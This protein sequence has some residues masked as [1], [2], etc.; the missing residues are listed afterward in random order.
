VGVR[1]KT[2]EKKRTP[3]FRKISKQGQE[4][5]P[6]ASTVS[7]ARDL[8][9]VGPGGTARPG[10]IG[11]Q[12]EIERGASDP[13][14]PGRRN[15]PAPDE[16]GRWM[17]S[18]LKKE[19]VEGMREEDDHLEK[20]VPGEICTTAGLVVADLRDDGRG[21]PHKYR[22]PVRGIAHDRRGRVI[23]TEAGAAP[24]KNRKVIP[25]N[26][27][28]HTLVGAGGRR[29]ARSTASN[30]LKPGALSAGRRYR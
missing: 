9:R 2:K 25:L 26:R 10:L 18:R 22:R 23:E 5:K 27:E 6:R 19:I 13:L 12:D 21:G 28:L 24:P 3:P 14:P 17:G 11:S 20:V 8:D 1:R 29:G 7:G 30:V 4:A 15:Q 16:M